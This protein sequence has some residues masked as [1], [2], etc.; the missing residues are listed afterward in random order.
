MCEN[1]KDEG[2]FNKTKTKKLNASGWMYK[3]AFVDVFDLRTCVMCYVEVA[4]NPNRGSLL[5]WLSISQSTPCQDHSVSGDCVRNFFVSVYV[6]FLTNQQRVFLLFPC[7]FTILLLMCRLFVAF[8]SVS[9]RHRQ[10]EPSFLDN[11]EQEPSFLD[12]QELELL[13]QWR[14]QTVQPG[15]SDDIRPYNQVPVTT[16]DHTTRCQWRHQTVQPRASD[17]IRPYNQAPVTSDRTTRCH[18]RHHTVQPGLSDD[19]RPNLGH[20]IMGVWP[21]PMRLVFR[22]M[23]EIY[24]CSWCRSIVYVVEF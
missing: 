5:S 20:A 24:I 9:P 4:M 14:H 19:I 8:R 17:D 6:G 16:S 23:A 18:W 15:P 13:S 7:L 21:F 12:N 22:P 11:Q 1:Q 2:G 3:N 10:R